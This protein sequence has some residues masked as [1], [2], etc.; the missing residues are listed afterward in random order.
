MALLTERLV[1]GF[2]AT[3]LLSRNPT[4]Q[5]AI[6]L[7]KLDSLLPQKKPVSISAAGLIRPLADASIHARLAARSAAGGCGS[8]PP[9][10]SSKD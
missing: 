4:V 2:S 8:T 10:I 1:L 9:P 3:P 7:F 5:K 6:E